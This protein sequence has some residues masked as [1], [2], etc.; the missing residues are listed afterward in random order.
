MRFAL[1]V[2]VFHLWLAGRGECGLGQRK[3]WLDLNLGATVRAPIARLYHC[4]VDPLARL[5]IAGDVDI[6]DV[7]SGPVGATNRVLDRAHR[8][9]GHHADPTLI[10]AD[11]RGVTADGAY[12][13]QLVVQAGIVLVRAQHP[14]QFLLIHRPVA[15]DDDA[16]HAAIDRIENHL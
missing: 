14:G 1:R 7:I 11:G 15:T 13:R 8:R 16:G 3:G 6:P 12:H 9:V 10:Q 4:Q 2:Q 5:E